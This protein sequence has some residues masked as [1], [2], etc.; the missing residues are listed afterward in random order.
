[1]PTLKWRTAVELLARRKRVTI[2]A[3]PR[4]S[5]GRKYKFILP[6]TT[7]DE[8][9]IHFA[10][11]IVSPAS[12]W[13]IDPRIHP[14]ILDLLAD[15]ETDGFGD[16]FITFDES[17]AFKRATGEGNR[18]FDPPAD[19]KQEFAQPFITRA[20][21]DVINDALAQDACDERTEDALVASLLLSDVQGEPARLTD[22][23]VSAPLPSDVPGLRLP[24][25]LHSDL[26]TH[27]LL[28]R[29][30]W[31]RPKYTMAR[32][33]ESGALH[34]ADEHTRR[35]FWTWLRQNDRRIAPRDRPKLADIPIWPDQTGS[36]CLLSD[37]C[38]PRSRRVSAALAGFIRRP[39]EQVRRSK[40][41]P[42]GTRGRTSIRRLPTEVEISLWLDQRMAAFVDREVADESAIAELHSFEADLAILLKD[43]GIGRLLKATGVT[44]PAL[45]QDGSI[46]RRTTLVTPGRSIDR[47]ALRDRF[48]LKNRQHAATLDKLS[49]SLSAPTA[50]MLLETF[51]E[52]SSSFDA[53][54]PRLQ[55][56]LNGTQSGDDER[57]QLSN[58]SD[59]ETSRAFFEWLAT[60]PEDVLQCHIPCVLRHVLHPEGPAHWAE[61][62]TDIPF[63][64]ARSRDGLR[65]VS[66]RTAQRR[67]VYLPDTEDV[68]EAIIQHDPGVLLVIDHVREVAEPVR[69]PLRNLGIRSLREALKEPEFV[70]AAGETAPAGAE[71]VHR[72]R[73]LRSNH[74]RRTFLKR[75]ATLGVETNLVWHDWHARLARIRTIRFASTVEAHYRFRGRLYPVLT[76][77]GCDPKSGTFWMKKDPA[78]GISSVYEAIAAQLVF[79]PSARPVDCL[80]LERTLDLEI[81][82]PTYG[83]PHSTSPGPE[84]GDYPAETEDLDA[85]G[86]SGSECR[87]DEDD[88]GEAVFGHSP[89]EPDPS[90]NA[91]H[92]GPI[93]SIAAPISQSPGAA[94]ALPPS[95]RGPHRTSS[96]NTSKC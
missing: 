20:Y 29:R 59:R 90:R 15:R 43:V 7:W 47:L 30:K 63:I 62:F 38:D 86:D 8:T 12:E 94:A 33:L 39:Y 74:F 53:L 76:A 23:H 79:K 4:R 83:R 13:Q 11:A 14:A 65:L 91:P 24:P 42:V 16:H 58:M 55:Q 48:L 93:S 27:P 84:D 10:L 81:R 9:A 56:F 89:F 17:D 61:I 3:A 25:I 96:W 87:R 22:L 69:E 51:A 31:R 85:R 44:L 21:L 66:L 32:F 26:A 71:V 28:R 6:V 95:R 75:L 68:A 46:G 49:P 78:I 50:T 37:L 41:V 45:A 77:A 92:P 67:A 35:L 73:T 60:Q 40:L 54:Q 18:Y 5:T 36:L 34:A 80:A 70:S 64:P 57:H 72:L 52:D 82:D 88:L 19:L 1:M 2:P